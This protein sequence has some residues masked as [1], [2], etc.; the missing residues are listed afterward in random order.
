MAEDINWKKRFCEMKETVL[1][2]MVVLRWEI[3][4]TLEDRPAVLITLEM[5]N[6]WQQNNRNSESVTY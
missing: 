5:R 1:K 3:R 6:G 2:L 4:G